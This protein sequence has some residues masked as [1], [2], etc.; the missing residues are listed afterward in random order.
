MNHE[1]H[2]AGRK[3]ETSNK[4]YFVYASEDPQRLPH[5]ACKNVNKETELLKSNIYKYIVWLSVK[6][7]T[8]TARS[9]SEREG[10]TEPRASQ[11]KDQVLGVRSEAPAE[12]RGGEDDARMQPWG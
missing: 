3:T 11:N 8:F 4:S 1:N 9:F 12:G 10:L 7:K 6:Q 2:L 5:R